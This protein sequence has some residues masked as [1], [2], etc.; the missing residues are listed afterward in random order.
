MRY[1]IPGRFSI[2]IA[3]FLAYASTAFSDVP[4]LDDGRGDPLI[5]ITALSPAGSAPLTLGTTV[6]VQVT[7]SYILHESRGKVG[8]VVMDDAKRNVAETSVDVPQGKAETSVRL[9]LVVPPSKRLTVK[10]LLMTADGKAFAKDSR[11]YT[12]IF[13]GPL[14]PVGNAPPRKTK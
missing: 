4:G 3:A 9:P 1:R 10:A 6:T 11:T 13:A 14:A 2:L 7:V 5:L 12:N 8:L